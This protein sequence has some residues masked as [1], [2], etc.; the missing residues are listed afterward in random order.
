MGLENSALEPAGGV[1]VTQF[2]LCRHGI[3]GINGD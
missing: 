2:C 1:P 3:I